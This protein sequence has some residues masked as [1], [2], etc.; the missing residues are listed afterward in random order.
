MAGIDFNTDGFDELMDE[1]SS[2]EIECLECGK[3]FS[4]SLD[5]FGTVVTCPHCNANIELISE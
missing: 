2:V 3:P 4:V 1:L 5:D